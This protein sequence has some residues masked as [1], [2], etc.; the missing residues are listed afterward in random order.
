MNGWHSGYLRLRSVVMSDYESASPGRICPQISNR[1]KHQGQ[2]LS[3]VLR[4][5]LLHRRSHQRLHPIAQPQPPC[6]SKHPGQRGRGSLSH[7]RRGLIVA[8][9]LMGSVT[10]LFLGLGTSPSASAAQSVS[11]TS[12]T[13]QLAS[14]SGHPTRPEG[15]HRARS[16]AC[17]GRVHPVERHPDDL[18]GSG[19]HS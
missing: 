11:S 15:D 4:A 13:G 16:G 3:K 14:V 18:C 6:P 10:G 2:Q 9:A 19:G 5:Q 12:S 8:A 17:S 7:M 1:T